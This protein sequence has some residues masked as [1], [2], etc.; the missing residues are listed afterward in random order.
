MR[1]LLLTVTVLCCLGSSIISLAA[2]EAP[3]TP[4]ED[5]EAKARQLFVNKWGQ[6]DLN[7]FKGGPFGCFLDAIEKG[8]IPLMRAISWMYPI[9]IKY[10]HSSTGRTALEIARY[11][12]SMAPGGTSLAHNLQQ[13][14]NEL[15][16]DE[17]SGNF[18][19]DSNVG[20]RVID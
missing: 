6:E 18:G 11:R 19:E 4:V 1:K 5:R 10:G 15:T 9:Q 16:G 13:I 17:S 12:L 2:A 20:V 14:V 7:F 8:D 3:L